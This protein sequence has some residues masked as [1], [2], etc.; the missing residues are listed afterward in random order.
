[1]DMNSRLRDETS[2]NELD[3]SRC[4]IENERLV[5]EIVNLKSQLRESNARLADQASRPATKIEVS[6]P[7][8]SREIIDLQASHDTLARQLTSQVKQLQTLSSQNVK[9]KENNVFLKR[10][11]ENNLRLAEERDSALRRI[12]LIE[13]NYKPL[14]ER[15]EE[16]NIEL[17]SEGNRWRILLD[18]D[19]DVSSPATIIRGLHE[20]RMRNAMLVE[21][22]GR[23][24]LEVGELER[25]SSGLKNDVIVV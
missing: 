6:S 5:Q 10:N 25:L 15:I 18:G 12:A 13:S 23:I 8:A 7:Q 16:E 22:N 9:L 3:S 20:A 14:V 1:M 21:E 2:R 4:Q 11:A 24:S 19:G 17:K